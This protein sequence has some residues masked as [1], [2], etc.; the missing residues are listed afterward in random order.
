MNKVIT[1]QTINGNQVATWDGS[2]AKHY[3]VTGVDRYGK[4][5]KR[6]NLT[7]LQMMNLNIWRGTKWLVRY[8]GKR[9]R[10]TTVYN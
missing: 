1:Y 10:V 9:E 3:E 8:D 4:R 2:Q 6:T 5:F 7:Y